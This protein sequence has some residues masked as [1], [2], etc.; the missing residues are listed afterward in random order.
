MTQLPSSKK[1]YRTSPG[2]ISIFTKTFPNLSFY[3]FFVQLVFKACVKAKCGQYDKKAW[4]QNSFDL[5]QALE[6]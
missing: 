1:E 3:S 2:D 6:N 4:Y 5:F